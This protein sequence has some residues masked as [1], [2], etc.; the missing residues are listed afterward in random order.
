[1]KMHTKQLYFLLIIFVAGGVAYFADRYYTPHAI[2]KMNVAVLTL[3][4][5]PVSARVAETPADQEKGLMGVKDLSESEGM[6]FKIEK[7][8]IKQFWNKD[9]LMP[10]DLVW[11]TNGRV[12]GIEHNIPLPGI[13][14][15]IYT[16]PE[17]ITSV[18]EIRGG[19]AERHGLRVGD[20]ILG[21]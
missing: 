5:T 17:V 18:L 21:L 16:S 11:I 19:W 14:P 12:V 3:A 6:L 1:M 20:K 15:D 7:P 13:D 4:G 9:M 2:Y 8:G 10:F